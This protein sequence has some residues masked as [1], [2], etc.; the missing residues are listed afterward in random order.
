M[1]ETPDPR[2]VLRDAIAAKIHAATCNECPGDGAPR[3]SDEQLAEQVMELFPAVTA[4][5]WY[6]GERG[7]WPTIPDAATHI[8]LVLRSEPVPVAPANRPEGETA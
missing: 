8:R 6:V 4:E 1:T 3:F 5:E 7:G 2:M